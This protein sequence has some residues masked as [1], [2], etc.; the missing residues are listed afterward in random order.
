MLLLGPVYLLMG[1]MGLVPGVYLARYASRITTLLRSGGSQ[2]LEAA[3]EA[4]RSF[5]RI[6]GSQRMWWPSRWSLPSR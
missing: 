1:G 2:D 4:Q 3:M 5:W 6:V